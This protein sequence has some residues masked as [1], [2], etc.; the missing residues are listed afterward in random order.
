MGRLGERWG[1][2]PTLHCSEERGRSEVALQRTKH[3]P[4]HCNERKQRTTSKYLAAVAPHA[5]VVPQAVGDACDDRVEASR[6]Y[7]LTHTHST[8]TGVLTH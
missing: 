5:V 6:A 4:P 8:N 2:V 3:L 1:G 7:S